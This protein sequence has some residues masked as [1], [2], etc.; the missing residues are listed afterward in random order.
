MTQAVSR[1]VVLQRT[2]DVVFA[3]NHGPAAVDLDPFHVG[4]LITEL[5][6]RTPRG[7][8]APATH[9]GDRRAVETGAEERIVQSNR[10]QGLAGPERLHKLAERFVE[11][12][13]AAT[14][15]GE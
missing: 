7:I 5:R 13:G 12:L 1:L 15:V 14:G 6:P 11:G 2:A 3:V 9:L 10:L 4:I 8:F